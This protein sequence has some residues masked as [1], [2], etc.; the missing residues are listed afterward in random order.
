MRHEKAAAGAS[1]RNELTKP[2]EA[3]L[4]FERP[5]IRLPK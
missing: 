4:E 1:R 2:A 3:M 5:L